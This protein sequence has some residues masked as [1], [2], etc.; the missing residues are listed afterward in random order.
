[1][2]KKK[3]KLVYNEIF[4][5]HFSVPRLTGREKDTDMDIEYFENI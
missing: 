5:P 1:M 3:R 4:L 2:V